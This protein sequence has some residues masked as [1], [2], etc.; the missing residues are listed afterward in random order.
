M[1][2][3]LWGPD[4]WYVI[5]VIAD[6]APDTF[7][8]Q[9]KQSYRRFYE[10]LA[11]VLPCPACAEHYR[12][13]LSR[14]PPEWKNRV[15]LLRWTIR[16]HNHANQVTGAPVLTEEEGMRRIEQEI[17]ARESGRVR[18]RLPTTW[19]AIQDTAGPVAVTL[20]III[21]VYGLYHHITRGK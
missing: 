5:H 8:E 15:D 20:A 19:E 17:K 18:G 11:D 1:G 12:Q 14:D 16:A 10:S 7:T 21:L 6:S 3:K 4:T 2:T 9:D 13:F